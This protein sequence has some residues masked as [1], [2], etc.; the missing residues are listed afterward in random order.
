MIGLTPRQR[1][2]YEA[3]QAGVIRV[4]LARIRKV[5]PAAI[6][7][8]VRDI[9]AKGFTVPGSARHKPAQER[10]AGLLTQGK[11]VPE[12]AEIMGITTQRAYQLRRMISD[13]EAAE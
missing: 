10:M 4:D 13:R 7:Q 1:E 9:E 12:A 3:L 5:S 6:T 11:S 8:M 2:V